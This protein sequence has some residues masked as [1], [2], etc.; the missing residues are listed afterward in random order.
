[1]QLSIICNISK[2]TT[3]VFKK[4]I[5]NRNLQD[6][7]H[8][9]SPLPLVVVLHHLNNSFIPL[10]ISSHSH[11]HEHERMHSS[12]CVVLHTFI[13]G[14]CFKAQDP[15]KNGAL[16]SPSAFKSGRSPPAKDYA[17]R[18]TAIPTDSEAQNKGLF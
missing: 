16:R 11:F 2:K 7:Y 18:I 3:I 10:T 5:Y 13:P 6:A 1:M 15:V 12:T 8:E 14:D 9:S 17:D 4:V